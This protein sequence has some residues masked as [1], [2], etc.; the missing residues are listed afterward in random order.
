MLKIRGRKPPQVQEIRLQPCSLHSQPLHLFVSEGPG[1]G[2]LA[3]L[4][5]KVLSAAPPPRSAFTL[6]NKL[7]VASRI[8]TRLIGIWHFSSNPC[9]PKCF[10]LCQTFLPWSFA[11]YCHLHGY[12]TFT[13]L[14]E[15]FLELFFQLDHSSIYIYNIVSSP[16]VFFN[17]KF[18][19]IAV[20]LFILV[21]ILTVYSHCQYTHCFCTYQIWWVNNILKV[22][23]H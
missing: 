14:Y 5:T 4:W 15:L 1:P 3:E 12:K 6:L 16:R 2:Q 17:L 11:Y 13:M 10:L 19:I 9:F 8:S 7:L 18:S 23:Q 20:F 22:S 21:W